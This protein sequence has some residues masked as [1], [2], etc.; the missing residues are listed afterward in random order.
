MRRIIEPMLKNFDLI[1]T[2][3]GKGE[4]KLFGFSYYLLFIQW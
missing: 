1:Y 2:Y 3:D 4:A